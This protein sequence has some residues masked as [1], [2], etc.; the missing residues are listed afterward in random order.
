MYEY[1]LLLLVPLYSS[2]HH[3][4]LLPSGPGPAPGFFLL[5]VY[6]FP[7]TGTCLG[8]DSGFLEGHSSVRA[9]TDAVQI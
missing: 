6:V 9:V 4:E 8:S 1:V 7:A 3:Q 2:V 5:K